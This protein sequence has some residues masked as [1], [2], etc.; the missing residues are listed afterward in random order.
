MI[1]VLLTS[2]YTFNRWEGLS[3]LY[4]DEETWGF[5]REYDRGCL[6]IPSKTRRRASWATDRHEGERTMVVPGG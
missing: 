2:C 3:E 4:W 1:P 6:E 5:R